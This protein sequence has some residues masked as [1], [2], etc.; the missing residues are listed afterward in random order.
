MSPRPGTLFLSGLF[1]FAQ[2]PDP[3]HPIIRVSTRMVEVNVVVHGKTGSVDN[4][5]K[6]DFR[7]LD[8]G[9]EQ[10]IAFFSMNSARRAQKATAP[11]P[12][13]KFTNRPVSGENPPSITVVL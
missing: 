11:Q 9:K 6:S 13:A 5:T 12:H 10:K 2:A 1:L 4:L 8:K 3:T 7:I